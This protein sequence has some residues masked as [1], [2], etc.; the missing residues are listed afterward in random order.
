MYIRHNQLYLDLTPLSGLSLE[1]L[2]L[3][4]TWINDLSPL[5]GLTNLNSLVIRLAPLED[6]SPLSGLIN[7]E[8]LEI[9]WI[10]TC[11]LTQ[12]SGLTNLQILDISQNGINDLSPL[13][14]CLDE[15]DILYVT[16]SFMSDEAIDAIAL[17]E[18]QGVIVIDIMHY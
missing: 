1:K 14:P 11:D 8:Y 18:E 6:I 9:S 12:L 4:Y 7:L 17:L 16:K 10:I 13:L 2:D 5:S 3:A 15:G